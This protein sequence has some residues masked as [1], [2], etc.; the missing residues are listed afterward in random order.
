MKKLA[1]YVTEWLNFFLERQ[2]VK[3]THIQLLFVIALIGLISIVGGL[4]VLP[5]GEPTSTIGESVWW[6]FL[7]L[8]DPG[9]LGDDEGTW[10]RTISTLLTV[11]GYV[12]FMGSMVAIITSWLN[13]KI[14]TLEQGLTRVTAN[15]H[16]VIL[17]WTNR[18]VHIAAELLQSTKRVKK[19]LKRHGARALKMIILSDDVSPHRLQELKDNQLIKKRAKEVI[20]RSGHAIDREHLRRVDSMHAS[21]IIIPSP[22]AASSELITPDVETIKTLLSLNAEASAA[23]LNDNM[24]FVVAEIQDENKI[25]AAQR[26]YRG[27][28]EV[29][30][31]D[32]IISRLIAQNIHHEGLSAVFNEL[33]TNSTNN[34]LYVI[35]LPDAAGK[36]IGALDSLFPKAIIFGTVREKGEKLIPLLNPNKNLI[37]E[38]NDRIVLL[39]R[40]LDDVEI[41]ADS[42]QQ[43]SEFFPA[44]SV[45]KRPGA[46]N[47]TGVSRLL[48]LGWNHHIP[49]LIKELGTYANEEFHI[50]LTSLRPMDQ[51]HDA[52]S[53]ILSN[54]DNIKCEHVVADYIR[55]S[56]L[57]AIEPWTYEHILLV[58]SDKM[59]DEEEADA[60][61]IVGYT[62]LEEILES[63]GKRP[64]ILMELT[65]PSNEILISSFRSETII[66]P[67]ILSNLLATVAMRRELFTVYNELFTVGGAEII[68]RN[69]RDYQLEPETLS[70]GDL[71]K[72][73]RQF[74][75][76]IIGVYSPGE[77]GEMNVRL[78]LPRHQIVKLKENTRLVALSTV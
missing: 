15:N 26:A 70:F 62:M 34:N 11:A 38:R 17:G 64:H 47:Y 40:N 16:V 3:G 5:A 68:F 28:L 35:E 77:S 45:K 36:P 67:L 19:F 8:S 49:S 59:A 27:P 53:H 12:V 72:H 10:R 25:K 46:D 75:D 60:R 57:S 39:A 71:E 43:I 14:R 21:V 23:R 30:S 78:N 41:S 33:L 22:A 58:S 4:L 9:Y 55:E 7:R 51:R 37:L 1:R 42:V 29:I 61:T 44:E 54:N 74:Q 50:T 32:T 24:P 48:V 2:F 63:A 31:S 18:T 20:L 6:A 65:D 73:V 56:R 66:G 13:R 52:I 69:L 76:I